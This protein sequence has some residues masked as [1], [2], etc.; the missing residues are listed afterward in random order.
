MTTELMTV[1]GD[2]GAPTIRRAAGVTIG[3]IVQAW[4]DAQRASLR[5]RRAYA[6]AVASF[7]AALQTTG[8]DLDAA[9]EAIALAAQAWAGQGNAAA[10]T[11]NQRLA[12]VSSCF[13]YAIRHGLLRGENPI[14]RVQRQ[15]VQAYGKAVALTPAAVRQKLQAIDRSA[16]DGHRDHA[17]LA[18]ALQTGRR[19]AEIAALTWSD[20]RLQDD[21]RATITFQ[22]CKG[23]KTM[24]DTI[25]PALTRTLLG[26]LQ[27]F[28][29]RQ[30]GDLP[31]DTPLWVSLATNGTRGK[32]LST[33]A[34][35][36]ICQERLGTGKAHVLRHSFARALEDAGAKVSEIQARLGH[37]SLATTGRYLAALRADENPHADALAALFGLDTE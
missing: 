17:L 28:Y 18:I 34:S 21:G 11:Y 36:Q 19:L 8:H 26:W 37:E 30:L 4:L 31:S 29:G 2:I 15:R 22:R 6:D 12:C 33:R 35:E 7:R 20:L 10:A 24:R 13:R 32:R 23:G 5:T 9:P 3:Q 25:P 1:S 14:A 16:L 27:A